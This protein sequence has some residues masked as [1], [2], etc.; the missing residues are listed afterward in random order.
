VYAISCTAPICPNKI[1]HFDEVRLDHVMMRNS[2]A[3]Q[4][5]GLVCTLDNLSNRQLG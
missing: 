5:E 2:P 4:L 3:S 1:L